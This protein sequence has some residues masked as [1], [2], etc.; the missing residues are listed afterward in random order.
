M[1]WSAVHGG[2]PPAR[3][4]LARRILTFASNFGRARATPFACRAS[5]SAAAGLILANIASRTSPAPGPIGR[6]ETWR[7]DRPQ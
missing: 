5:G 3:S 7:R 2:A 1:V 4:A 6:G